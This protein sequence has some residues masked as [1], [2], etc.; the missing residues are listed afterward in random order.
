MLVSVSG[1]KKVTQMAGTMAMDLVSKT[2]CQIGSVKS[3]K[4]SITNW[5]AYVPVMVELCPAASRPIAQIY[6]ALS[7]TVATR[8]SV[9]EFRSRSFE[10]S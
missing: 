2:R 1:L 9:A 10:A 8:A 3:R 5:P 4:P 7:P 6:L